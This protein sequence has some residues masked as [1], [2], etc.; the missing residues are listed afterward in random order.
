MPHV[1]TGSMVIKQPTSNGYAILWTAYQFQ[2][3]FGR[4][5]GNDVCVS[6]MNGD[7]DANATNVLCVR[8]AQSG[9][10]IDVMLDQKNSANIRINWMVVWQ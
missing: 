8:Y 2:R 6:A 4:P 1:Y 3:Q 7:W 9:Q 10:R 5:W